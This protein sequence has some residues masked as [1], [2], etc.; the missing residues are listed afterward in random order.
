MCR[1]MSGWRR[2]RQV[3]EPEALAGGPRTQIAGRPTPGH[4][5]SAASRRPRARI[6]KA[7]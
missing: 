7:T 2:E 3:R 6:S 4:P 5:F 1:E